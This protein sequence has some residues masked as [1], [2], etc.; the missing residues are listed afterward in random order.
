MQPEDLQDGTEW[1]SLA[2]EDILLGQ[3]AID[4]VP[5]LGGGAVFHAQQAAEKA[6]KSFLIAHGQSLVKTHEL[7]ALLRACLTIE[8]DFVHHLNA[9]QTLTPYISRFRYPLLGT[10]LRPSETEAREAIQLATELVDFVRDQLQ[11]MEQ[12]IMYDE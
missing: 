9:A 1:L 6:L 7:V 12:V 4:D 11:Q 10:P 3:R 8:P 5:V 2:E